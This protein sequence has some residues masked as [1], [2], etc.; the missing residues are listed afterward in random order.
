MTSLKDVAII[1]TITFL[2]LEVA[3]RIYFS[4]TVGSD[5]L[6]FGTPYCC[7]ANIHIQK[8]RE[9]ET[10]SSNKSNISDHSNVQS[11]YFKYMPFQKRS[12]HDEN[13]EFFDVEINSHGFRGRDYKIHK[14]EDVIRIVTLGASSTFGHYDKD[15]HTYPFF[16]EEKLRLALAG[17]GSCRNRKVFEVIN[18]GVPHLTSDNIL[19]LYQEEAQFLKPDIVT[20]YEGINDAALGSSDFMWESRPLYYRAIFKLKQ[21]FIIFALLEDYVGSK[22]AEFSPRQVEDYIDGIPSH[23][24]NN[25]RKIRELVVAQGGLF[26]AI[27]QQAQSSRYSEDVRKSVTYRQE[28]SDV[29]MELETSGKIDRLSLYLVTHSRIMEALREW[30]ESESVPLV[31][32]IAVLDHHRDLLASWVHLK[33]D[34]NNLLSDAIEEKVLQLYCGFDN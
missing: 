24:V 9:P 20:F 8:D 32:G 16:L 31:D 33:A 34:G 26:I 2:L 29:L 28:V 3:V 5:V 10:D 25:L 30:S 21:W 27:T 7:G 23:F 11:G 6:L 12:D 15:H 1:G 14:E 18:L 22:E 19:N 13:G 4:F 17:Y